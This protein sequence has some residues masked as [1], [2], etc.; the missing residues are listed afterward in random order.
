M[1]SEKGSQQELCNKKGQ[2]EKYDKWNVLVSGGGS[3]IEHLNGELDQ[4]GH[5]LEQTL[6][7]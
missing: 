3:I 1:K 5:S 2:P 7:I 4:W 6:Y